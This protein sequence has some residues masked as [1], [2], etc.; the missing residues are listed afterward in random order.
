MSIF[1]SLRGLA[2]FVAPLCNVKGERA[3]ASDLGQ[4]RRR[5]TAAARALAA[6]GFRA[7]RSEGR[8]AVTSAISRYPIKTSG[9]L[10]KAKAS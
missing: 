3:A 1:V 10:V 7:C 6:P 2:W 8:R 9:T 5:G 4:D